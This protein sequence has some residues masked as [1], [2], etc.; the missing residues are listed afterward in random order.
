[1]LSLCLIL[2]G[3][4]SCQSNKIPGNIVN[5]SPGY[6][7]GYIPRHITGNI[8]GH[9]QWIGRKKDGGSRD[10]KYYSNNS[11]EKMR[12]KRNQGCQK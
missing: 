11:Q 12:E 9:L 5:H 4:F 10:Y 8:P 2:P 3:I 1:M 6:T 7:P